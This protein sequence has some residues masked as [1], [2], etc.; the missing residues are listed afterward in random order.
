M[1]MMEWNK[2]LESG[3]GRIDRNHERLVGLINI[4]GE[5]M[6]TGHGRSI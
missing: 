6:S 3:H 4:L 2:S 1:V 5:A